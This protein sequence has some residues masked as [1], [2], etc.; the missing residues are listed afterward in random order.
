MQNRISQLGFTLIELLLVMAVVGILTVVAVPSY[1]QYM[2]HSWQAQLK[3]DMLNLSGQL[4]Q[5][6]SRSLTYTGFIPTQGYDDVVNNQLTSPV[7]PSNA[8]YHIVLKTVVDNQAI[9]LTTAKVASNWVMI[10]T[11]VNTELGLPFYAMTSQGLRCM[12]MSKLLPESVW[13]EGGCG[14]NGQ[15]W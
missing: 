15:S 12:D 13:K 14:R 4:H 8:Q 11:P 10:A 9:T 3:Q 6:Q 5:W 2:K 7:T 1:R